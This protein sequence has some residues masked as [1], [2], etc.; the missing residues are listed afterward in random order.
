M[1]SVSGRLPSDAR[2]TAVVELLLPAALADAAG[3]S[4]SLVFH[5]GSPD[6]PAGDGGA[7]TVGGLLELLR[8]RHPGVYHRIVDDA[9]NI[10]RYVNLYVDG[11][12]IR[13]LAGPATVLESGTVVLVLQSI[14]GG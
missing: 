3:G 4:R 7:A 5:P 8:D 6:R 10:R 2:G 14:A 13:D 1:C 11:E 12:D 9:G